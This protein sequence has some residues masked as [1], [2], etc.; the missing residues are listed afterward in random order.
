MKQKFNVLDSYNVPVYEKEKASQLLDSINFTNN[1]LKPGVTIYRSRH[2]ASFGKNSTYL[3]TDTSRLSHKPIYNQ[4]GIDGYERSN[5]IGEEKVEAEA[6]N[7]KLEEAAFGV[8]EEAAE[9][10]AKEMVIKVKMWFT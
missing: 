2:S 7:M 10:K 8:V 6:T 5:Q 4:E 1:N 9:D 3:S